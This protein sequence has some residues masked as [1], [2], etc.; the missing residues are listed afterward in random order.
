MLLLRYAFRVSDLWPEKLRVSDQAM[1]DFMQD[2]MPQMIGRL[3]K[4]I[5]ISLNQINK[6]RTK[7]KQKYDTQL[8]KF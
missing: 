6:C 8:W 2:Y 5:L 7:F 4:C 3:G 1:R